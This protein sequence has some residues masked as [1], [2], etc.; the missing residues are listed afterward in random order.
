MKKSVFQKENF[1]KSDVGKKENP[2]VYVCLESVCVLLQCSYFTVVFQIY[3]PP[4][5]CL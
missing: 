4:P 5:A 3:C 1:Q 2:N